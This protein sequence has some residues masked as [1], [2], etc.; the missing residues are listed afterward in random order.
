MSPPI[1]LDLGP[2]EVHFHGIELWAW[3]LGN[4]AADDDADGRPF[5]ALRPFDRLVHPQPQGVGGADGAG[6]GDRRRAGLRED[7]AGRGEGRPSGEGKPTGEDL[8][9]SFAQR[10]GTQRTGAGLWPH[11]LIRIRVSS[12]ECRPD[13]TRGPA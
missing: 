10:A 13:A 5:R 12:E 6:A 9:V 3:D 8:A 11:P 4:L 2:V 1:K 7:E